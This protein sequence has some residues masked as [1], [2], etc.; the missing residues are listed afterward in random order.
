MK[1]YLPEQAE[2]R[3]RLRAARAL[4]DLTV[5]QLADLI[6]AE[7][8]LGER[9][10]RKLE[11]GESQLTPPILRELAVRLELPYEWFSV[12]DLGAAIGGGTFDDRIRALERAQAQLWE[13]IHAG[14]G[15]RHVP[16]EEAPTP[17]RAASP[18]RGRRRNS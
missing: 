1:D 12:P 14:S 11:S 6:P 5:Q 13:M 2:L 4:R 9:T 7:A 3:C 10:L 17:P 18:R 15:I 16:A 8:R